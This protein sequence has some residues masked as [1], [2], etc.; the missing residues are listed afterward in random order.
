MSDLPNIPITPETSTGQG[1]DPSGSPAQLAA[2]SDACVYFFPG[3]STE[4]PLEL[5]GLPG[6]PTSQSQVLLALQQRL[7]VLNQHPEGMST[8]GNRARFALHAAAAKLLDPYR[9]PDAEASTPQRTSPPVADPALMQA[10]AM[11]GGWNSTALKYALRSG[12]PDATD[13]G[14][15][16]KRV[17]RL[18]GVQAPP[19][20]P[21]VQS[22]TARHASPAPVTLQSVMEPPELLFAPDAQDP[23]RRMIAAAAWALG[24]VM[25]LLLALIAV[26]VVISRMPR[27]GA[28][29]AATPSALD[30]PAASSA[31]TAQSSL[32]SESKP[33]TPPAPQRNHVEEWPDFVRAMDECASSLRVG[34]AAGASQFA[35]TLAKMGA[36]WTAAG[37]DERA[38]AMNTIV[39]AVY[40]A[41]GDGELCAKLV[42]E[43][44]SAGASLGSAA[45]PTDT[46][47]LPGIWSAGLQSRLSSE[48][49]LPRAAL[50]AL[51]ESSD[52]TFSKGGGAPGESSFE[53]GAAAMLTIL[54]Q[55]LVPAVAATDDAAAAKSLG[56]WKRWS[57]ASAALRGPQSE[58]N[59]IL[60]LGAL[61]RLLA[62]PLEPTQCR[63]VFD[64]VSLLVAGLPWREGDPSR[65]WLLHAFETPSVSVADLFAVTQSLATRSG[66]P[67]V[68]QTMVLA[69]GASDAGRGQLR[70]QYASVWGLASAEARDAAMAKWIEAAKNELARGDVGDSPLHHLAAA[71]SLA[72]L[73]AA[74]A[75][76]WAGSPDIAAPFVTSPDGGIDKRISAIQTLGVEP[77]IRRE[78]TSWGVQYGGLS[79]GAS[80]IPER[81]KMLGEYSGSLT[82]ADAGLVAAEALRGPNENLR[83][84]AVAFVKR[85]A[86]D[87]AMVAALLEEAP[88]IPQTG[89]STELIK[90]VAVAAIPSP[91]DPGWR[92]SV[93]RALVSRLLE[94]VAG[95]GE[96][97]VVD[98]VAVLLAEAYDAQRP[99]IS[100][101]QEPAD[102]PDSSPRA[103]GRVKPSPESAA[104]A[105][106]AKLLREAEAAVPTGREPISLGQAAAARAARAK[107]VKGRIQ[108][109]A[110]E[111]V[112][113]CELLAFVISSERTDRA[114]GAAKVLTELGEARRT[115]RHVFPQIEAAE[116]AMLKLWLLRARAEEAS[117]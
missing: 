92:V 9:R 19:P 56:A 117:S 12:G 53:S 33:A 21:P 52:R 96:T 39:E 106:R 43:V 77:V 95:T 58:L 55:T 57:A 89:P 1:T 94:L 14:T 34:E 64:A 101:S 24:G 91:R 41:S 80:K 103:R 73:N 74:A 7:A 17:S 13:A 38:A 107:L 5:L 81:R 60:T 109:F 112:A 63:E 29:S 54:S 20:L 115:A 102:D 70:D 72:R 36:G 26:V 4:R 66:A 108:E 48:R 100:T 114:E 11:G 93:R 45:K 30:N 111:Q 18:T 86:N 59:Q 68:D 49:D 2:A 76:I 75:A 79:L 87:A 97:G 88:E 25:A 90:A 113:C 69:A 8:V 40:A 42:T 3:T 105:L 71:V 47:V 31:S 62:G 116:R 32:A 51:N 83:A 22:P 61:D 28:T 27:P 10:I 99:T 37:S 110:A 98:E 50:R 78:L 16:L 44:G 23:A 65:R 85:H 104:A 67:G 84:D 15:I 46:E 6:V 35:V 82:L